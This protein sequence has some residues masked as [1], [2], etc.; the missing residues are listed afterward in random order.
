MQIVGRNDQKSD[1]LLSQPKVWSYRLKDASR[2]GSA[3][4]DDK[5]AKGLE[6]EAV[7]GHGE[8]LIED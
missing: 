1:V 7:P 8:K 6:Y 2:F 4:E 5:E 3:A